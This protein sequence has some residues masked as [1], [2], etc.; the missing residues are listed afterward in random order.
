MV[1]AWYLS[2]TVEN[3]NLLNRPEDARI[4]V[5][6]ELHFLGVEAMRFAITET[7]CDPSFMCMRMF[8]DFH[9]DKE[10]TLSKGVS[11]EG[12][13]LVDEYARE[14]IDIDHEGMMVQEGGGFYDIRE[15]NDRWIRMEVKPGDMLIIPGGAYHRFILDENNHMKGI[16]LSRVPPGDDTTVYRPQAD[17][18]DVR[19]QYA[20]RLVCTRCC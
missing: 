20:Q 16:S 14:H 17:N 7:A 4:V 12:D 15:Q 18:H 10:V 2:E 3:P 5:M 19:K 1:L 11:E 6:C 9:F 8:K 13:K